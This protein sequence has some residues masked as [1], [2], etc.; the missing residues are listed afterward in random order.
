MLKPAYLASSAV[1]VAFGAM[2]MAALA[3][4]SMGNMFAPAPAAQTAT[5]QNASPSQQELQQAS[6]TA[7]P[8]LATECPP[9]KVRPGQETIFYYGRGK[10]GNPK[11]LNYQAVIDKQSRNCVVSNGLITVKMGMAGRL[12]LGPSGTQTK[13]DIPVRFSVERDDVALYSEKYQV[14][15]AIPPPA[16]S[17]EF[18]KVVDNVAI[19]YTGGEKIVIWVGFDSR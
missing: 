2:A 3:G 15:V 19:P 10:V 4:C 17:A 14:S 18:V 6:S 9:I 7:L 13:V 12:L 5:L 1:R 8:A 16:Q 11:D